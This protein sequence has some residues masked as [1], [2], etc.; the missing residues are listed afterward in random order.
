MS[1]PNFTK[2]HLTDIRLAGEAAQQLLD[3]GAMNPEPNATEPT[4]MTIYD[5][6]GQPYSADLVE[7]EKYR[8]LEHELA[9][10]R[11]E[12]KFEREEL[13]LL[14]NHVLHAANSKEARSACEQMMRERFDQDRSEMMERLR[15][16]LT[17]L[18]AEVDRL[19]AH[20]EEL[21]AAM[22][23]YEMDVDEEPPFKHRDMIA[24]AQATLA[25]APTPAALN[26]PAET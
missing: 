16:A 26:P 11:K 15:S 6:N 20:V 14:Q 9:E 12:L 2:Q 17:A 23:R 5:K 18:R 21:I 22:G 4:P 10:A 7:G 24:R 25:T 19:R 3:G 8:R 1:I 13:F